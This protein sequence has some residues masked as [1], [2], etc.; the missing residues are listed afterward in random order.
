MF[1]SF[2]NIYPF[3]IS[4]AK[5]KFEF[6]RISRHLCS[7]TKLRSLKILKIII[8]S[9][10]CS[11]QHLKKIRHYLP[12]MFI[13][14]N[15]ASLCSLFWLCKETEFFKQKNSPLSFSTPSYNNELIL[16][17]QFAMFFEVKITA[18]YTVHSEK[19]ISVT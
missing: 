14:V 17:Q 7:Q 4:S 19:I 6:E 15:I 13:L 5:P 1:S 10:I 18:S 8:L 3:T 2:R 9:I 12:T 16:T 11:R